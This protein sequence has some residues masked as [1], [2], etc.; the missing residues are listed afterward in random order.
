[1]PIWIEF[2]TPGVNMREKVTLSY[3]CVARVT[4]N[5][6]RGIVVN[7]LV[8]KILLWAVVEWPELV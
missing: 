2:R 6:S 8:C 7:A 1:M 3:S 4:F 5:G